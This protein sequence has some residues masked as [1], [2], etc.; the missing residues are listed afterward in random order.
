LGALAAI[1]GGATGSPL[2]TVSEK[3]REEKFD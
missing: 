2:Q 3:R 1:F